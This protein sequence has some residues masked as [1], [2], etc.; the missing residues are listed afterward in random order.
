MLASLIGMFG[1]ALWDRSRR[2]L[3]L[4]RDRLGIKPLYYAYDGS[5]LVF[6]SEIK[7]ILA[8]GIV[9]RELNQEALPRHLLYNCLYGEETLFRGIKEVLPGHCLIW[10]TGKG[11][12]PQVRCWW[13]LPDRDFEEDGR[14]D[15]AETIEQL[16]NYLTTSVKRRLIADVPVGVFLSGG[17]DSSLLVAIASQEVR[18]PLKTFSIGFPEEKG[19]E[20]IMR[21]RLCI[22]PDPASWRMP[23]STIGKPV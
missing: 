21:T 13:D 9:P 22:H 1:F 3:F 15:L 19:N 10:D 5:S 16:R 20:V 6:G 11:D 4:A 14:I 12:E 2:V 17:L 7:A 23:A 18:G 8:S